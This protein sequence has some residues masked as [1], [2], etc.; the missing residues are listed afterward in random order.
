[1]TAQT[2]MTSGDYL[3]TIANMSRPSKFGNVRTEIDG[4]KFDSKAEAR[5]YAVLRLREKAGEVSAIELQKPYAL[6][7]SNGEVVCTYVAD[8]AFYDHVQGRERVVD[9]KGG[10]ATQTAVFRI[11]RKLMR[12]NL[13]I[14]VE[15][16]EMGK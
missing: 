4:I 15:V 3:E 16:E 5:F 1:M 8:F 11:K 9:V 13:G 12:A 14:Q 7:E 2:R 10:K 6:K